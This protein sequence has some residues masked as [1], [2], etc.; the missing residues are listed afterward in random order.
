MDAMDHLLNQQLTIVRNGERQPVSGRV[1]QVAR[2][3]FF[4]VGTDVR[5]GDVVVDGDREFEITRVDEARGL[6]GPHHIEAR[7]KDH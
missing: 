5:N 1:D 3:P 2:M 6:A 7:L 4:S